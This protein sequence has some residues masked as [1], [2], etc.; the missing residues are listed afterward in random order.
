MPVTPLPSEPRTDTR[1]ERMIQRLGSATH[2]Y[3]SAIANGEYPTQEEHNAL[4]MMA[5][6]YAYHTREMLS[7]EPLEEASVEF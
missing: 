1:L 6:D 4:A 7:L 5:Y 2:A 3:L